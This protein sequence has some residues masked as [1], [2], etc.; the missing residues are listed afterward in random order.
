MISTL[1]GKVQEKI[2]DTLIV[3]VGGVGYGVVMPLSVLDGIIDQDI[4]IYIHENIKEDTYSLYGFLNLSDKKLFEQLLSVKNVGP[5]AAIAILDIGTSDKVRMAIAA[6]DVKILQT[7]KGVGKRA[8]EQIVVELRDK[9]GLPI[10]GE[11][12]NL[13]N[14]SGISM[15]DEATQALITLGYSESDAAI[16]LQGIDKNLPIEERI[17]Q[18]LKAR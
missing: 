15:Q 4:K 1:T 11:A 14:R 9:V 5:K 17:R 13:V 10:S 3:N 16:A 18:A 6:G 2:N 7:A 12:E 8:A